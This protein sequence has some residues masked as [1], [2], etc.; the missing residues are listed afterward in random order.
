MRERLL[1]AIL[2]LSGVGVASAQNVRMVKLD[3]V[4]QQ[5]T[6]KSFE[7]TSTVDVSTFQLCRE[8]GT[9]QSLGA[10]PLIT[11]DLV[12]DPA[13]EVTVVY[14]AI[15]ETGTGI[16]LYISGPFGSASNML[17]YVQYKGVAGFRESVAVAAGIWAAGTFVDGDGPYVYIG[18][19]TQDGHSFWSQEVE[20]PA[21]DLPGLSAVGALALVLALLTLGLL[22]RS[23]PSR[24]A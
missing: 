9:Y 21:V 2:M 15:L 17:D 20:S 11:G 12:L 18:D 16:G 6:L 22:L 5:V 4:L 8:P 14:T 10:V 23:S 24:R 3:E 19:G 1:I 7:P 13:E